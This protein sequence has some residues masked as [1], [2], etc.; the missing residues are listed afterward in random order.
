MISR[1]QIDH[2]LASVPAVPKIVRA[3]AQTLDAGDLVKAADIAGNDGALMLYLRE[4]VNKPIFGFRDEIK[5]PRQIFGVLGLSRARQIIYGYYTRLLAPKK[6][7]VFHL[8]TRTF[9]EL[10]AQ[11]M[12]KWEGVM[13]EI[14]CQ[15]EEISKAVSIIPATFAACEG[16]FSHDLETLRLLR[17]QKAISYEAILIKTTGCNFFDLACMIAEKWELSDDMIGFLRAIGDKESED[18]RVQYLKLLLQYELSRP[19]FVQSGLNDFFELEA[20]ASPEQIER[21]FDRISKIE[22]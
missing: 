13:E 5:A 6:W 16:I 2:Y 15:D 12:V 18:E 21:F 1:T 10:Q 22:A 14:G 7:E 20:N 17:E 9:Q 4:I 19:L 8:D 3:C 11:L